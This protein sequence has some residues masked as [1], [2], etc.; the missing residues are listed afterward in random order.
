MFFEYPR[1]VAPL[2]KIG[3]GRAPMQEI[4]YNLTR[5]SVIIGNGGSILAVAL[6]HDVSI[7]PVIDMEAVCWVDLRAPGGA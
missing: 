5:V 4:A 3:E 7:R 6:H 1:Q 2:G